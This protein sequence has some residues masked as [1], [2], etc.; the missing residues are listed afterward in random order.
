MKCAETTPP[1]KVWYIPHHDVY[2]SKKVPVV[3]DTNTQYA[4]ISLN[5]QLLQVQDII[6]GLLGI[7]CRFRKERIAISYDIEQLFYQVKE[8][9]KHR[10]YLR[11]LWWGGDINLPQT[12]FRMTVHLFG[13]KSAPRCANYELN[14]SADYAEEKYGNKAEDIVRDYLYVD[15]GL[16]CRKWYS[17]TQ[18]S[19]QL[20]GG[21]KEPYLRKIEQRSYRTLIFLRVVMS[22]REH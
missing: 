6:N 8:C 11:F 7:L 19:L 3:F 4:G 5:G 20:A 21:Y 15:D 2:H 14:V 12:E 10:A 18:N 17:S 9:E 16:M 13:V 1:A 22:S